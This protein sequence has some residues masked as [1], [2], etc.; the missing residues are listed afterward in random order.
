LEET[1]DKYKGAVESIAMTQRDLIKCEEEKLKVCQALVSLQMEYTKVQEEMSKQKYQDASKLVTYEQ[2][3]VD[4]TLQNKAQQENIVSLQKEKE[5][6]EAERKNLAMELGAARR[7]LVDLR[8][9]FLKEQ[10]RTE[11]L[12]VEVVNLMNSKEETERENTSL[13]NKLT[14]ALNSRETSDAALA[15]KEAELD[16]AGLKIA[17]LQKDLDIQTSERIK[18]E[19]ELERLSVE[20]EEKRLDMERGVLEEHRSRDAEAFKMQQ[21]RQAREEMLSNQMR[22]LLAEKEALLKNLSTAQR[23]TREAEKLTRAAQDSEAQAIRERKRLEEEVQHAREEGHRRLTEVAASQ[24]PKDDAA[25]DG[26]EEVRSLVRRLEGSVD[27]ASRRERDASEKLHLLRTQLRVLQDK[28]IKMHCALL[29]FAP[30]GDAEVVEEF[31]VDM[32]EVQR[33]SQRIIQEA[34][35]R[36]A[37][38]MR[39]NDKLKEDT[40]SLYKELGDAR[41]SLH[42][43]L[44]KAQKDAAVLQ[45]ELMT[46][47]RF[48]EEIEGSD[49]LASLPHLQKMQQQIMEDVQSIKKGGVPSRSDGETANGQGDSFELLS[50]P[51]LLQKCRELADQIKRLKA[52]PRD[53]R[54]LQQRVDFLE[55]TVRRL[56]AERSDL[57]AK[58]SSAEE[59]LDALQRHFKDLTAG[60]QKQIVSLQKGRSA[61]PQ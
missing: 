58:S 12:S 57:L 35:D 27:D 8:E 23:K 37:K 42:E 56:E 38:L 24:L 50:R 49:G 6:I 29:D 22:D 47:R 51:E 18:K 61:R 1:K 40:K 10:K 54:L 26:G 53:T 36:E 34:K 5:A 46:L 60:Y 2:D 19:V 52:L 31:R 7:S 21:D 17:Q 48:K 28:L 32:D 14:D 3:V 55:K 44:Q 15:R 43:A 16:E 59:Q 45:V 11:E 41:V 13:Q 30:Q 4:L 25:R 20:F 39:E 9:D 33:E